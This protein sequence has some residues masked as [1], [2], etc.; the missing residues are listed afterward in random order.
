MKKEL[1][2]KEIILEGK[3]AN[4][5]LGLIIED[6]DKIKNY[7]ISP[8]PKIEPLS[9]FVKNKI[10]SNPPTENQIKA[11][12]I[13]LNTPDI[14][15]IQGPPGTGKTTVITAIIERINELKDK[16]NL[17]GQVLVVGYQH[18]AVSNLTQR[19]KVNSLPAIKFGNKDEKEEIQRYEMVL[20]WADTLSQK[21]KSQCKNYSEQKNINQLDILLK[22]Y[23]ETPTNQAGINFL[24]KLKKHY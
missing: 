14:A 1:K 5:Y 22:G 3:S 7:Q 21:A 9:E 24:E 6:S 23:R 16:E 11:I 10:F 15:V 19:L 8:P 17:K 4:P 18:E 12:D 2:A 20:K 13:A